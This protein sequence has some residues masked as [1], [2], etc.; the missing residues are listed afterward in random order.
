[1][2]AEAVSRAAVWQAVAA[3]SSSSVMIEGAKA[4]GTMALGI[5]V[6]H[7]PS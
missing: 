5:T 6:D 4:V 7:A 2:R 1:M 3:E